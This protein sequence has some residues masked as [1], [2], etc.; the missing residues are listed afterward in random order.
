[1]IDKPHIPSFQAQKYTVIPFEPVL[2]V[3]VND[4]NH[5]Y[6]RHSKQNWRHIYRLFRVENDHAIVRECPRAGDQVYKKHVDT[7]AQRPSV[8][9]ATGKTAAVNITTVPWDYLIIAG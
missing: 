9:S 1:M 6:F 8:P 2:I 7:A 3:E 5:L 4:V